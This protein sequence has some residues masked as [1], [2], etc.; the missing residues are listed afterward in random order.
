S[1][2]ASRRLCDGWNNRTARKEGVR[3]GSRGSPTLIAPARRGGAGAVTRAGPP[4]PGAVLPSRALVRS[5]QQQL[6]VVLRVDVRGVDAGRVGE[7]ENGLVD[8]TAR[9]LP[10]ELRVPQ[11]EDAQQVP[12]SGPPATRARAGQP[13]ERLLGFRAPAD[14]VGRGAVRPLEEREDAAERERVARPEQVD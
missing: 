14:P 7:G 3:G 2:R 8:I 11:L 6:E 10:V 4:P 1:R 5:R 12:G 9:V 13:R